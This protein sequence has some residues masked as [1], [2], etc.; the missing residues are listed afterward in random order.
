MKINWKIRF[1]NK[2]WLSTFIGAFIVFGFTMF[3]LFGIETPIE[4]YDVV[5][6]VEAVLSAMALTGVLVDPTT[7]TLND[8]ELAMTYGSEEEPNEL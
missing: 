7:P 3:R 2:L 8:S 6:L 5:R 4:E 1:K